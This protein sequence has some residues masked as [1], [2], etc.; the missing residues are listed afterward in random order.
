[1]KRT[2]KEFNFDCWDRKGYLKT[3]VIE[4]KNEQDAV[5]IFKTRHPKLAFDKPYI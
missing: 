1:M 2:L 3:K 4:A 5:I